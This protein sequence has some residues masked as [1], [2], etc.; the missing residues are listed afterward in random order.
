MTQLAA[1]RH[2][3]AYW[4]HKDKGKVQ[5]LLCPFNCVLGEG[6]T[7]ICRGKQNIGGA[8]YAIN[9]GLTTSLNM[10]PIEKKPLYHFHPGAQIL[11]IGPNGCNLTCNFCQNYQISQQ[12]V[13]TSRLSPHDA[14]EMAAASGSLGVAYTYTEPLIWFEYVL[15]TA[16]EVKQRGM[17]NVLVTN[18]MINPEPLEELLP[19]IDALNVDIK[20]MDPVFYKKVCRGMLEP[21]LGAV[22]RAAQSAHV[23]I[24][25]LVIPGLND[26]D[27][28]FE[29]LTD[30]VAGI[31]EL[32]P[33]HFSRYYPAY[34]QDAP[35]T[36]LRTLERAAGIAAKK[37]KYVFIGNINS[38]W[39]DT[40][41]P[42]CKI[43]IIERS[44]YFVSR[45]DIDNGRC[46]HC[47]A[48]TGVIT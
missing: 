2:V 30:F 44:D 13:A 47:G 45:V 41:C 18:G 38:G 22:A 42:S 10:D 7:G 28:N 29:K 1:G 33:L 12:T 23:E 26:S 36:P 6:K 21:V 31:G 24:T 4:K 27:E 48:H 16:R 11:S 32:I 3:A 15:D 14:A 34:H 9:Y 20:S 39:T 35:A 46:R 40:H 17:A 37:L 19:W 8:L 25:N 5:C 43:A